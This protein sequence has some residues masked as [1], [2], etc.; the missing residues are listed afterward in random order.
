[1]RPIELWHKARPMLNPRAETPSAVLSF[2]LGSGLR[3]ISSLVLTRLLYPEA[4]GIIAILMSVLFMIEMLSD[5]G[6]VGLTIRHER[7]DDPLFLNTLWTIRIVRCAVNA[8]I[9]LLG[10]PLIAQLLGNDQI[11]EPLRVLALYFLANAVETMAF[12]LALRHRRSPL[13]NYI[14]LA[15]SAAST[16]FCVTYAYFARDHWALVFAAL[17]ERVLNAI[18][19]HFIYPNLRPRFAWDRAAIRDIF[20]FARYVLPTSMLTMAL[21]QFERVIFLR[22]F[23]LRAMGQYGVAGSVSSPVESLCS[24]ISH[25]VL[26]PRYAATAREQPD[27]L[28]QAFYQDSRKAMLMMFALP[29]VAGGAGQHLV[30]LLYDARYAPAGFILQCFMVRTVFLSYLRPSEQ[31]LTAIGKV[32]VQLYSNVL[33]AVVLVPLV[34]LGYHISGLAGFV[35]A[36]AFEPLIAVAYVFWMQRREGLLDLRRDAAYAFLA[37]ALWAAAWGFADFVARLWRG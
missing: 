6:V 12:P 7:G 5:I 34:L 28:K 35:V 32:Q 2:V 19:S 3:L 33:R 18:A 8:T 25:M 23:D 15:C 14:N 17:F 37:L 31:L 22:L 24:K 16:V 30:D 4:Y 26:Y 11:V 10:A 13:V 29:A 27:R 21:G 9:M 20:A 1:M 36:L